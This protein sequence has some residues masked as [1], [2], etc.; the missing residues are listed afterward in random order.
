MASTKSTAV[1]NITADQFI[2]QYM[3]G[4]ATRERA[5]KVSLLDRTTGFLSRVTDK[6][7]TAAEQTALDVVADSKTFAARV[8]VAWEVA[9]DLAE[10]ARLAERARQ[11]QRMAKRL[12]LK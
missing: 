12:G 8:E 7:V 2:A 5:P 1:Q 9:D 6:V 11:A 3:S 10:Q 4:Y